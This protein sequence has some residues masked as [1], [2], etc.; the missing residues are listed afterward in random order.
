M[1][2]GSN[3]L[4]GLLVDFVSLV[5]FSKF[6]V[7]GYA[8]VGMVAVYFFGLIASSDVVNLPFKVKLPLFF[9]IVAACIVL[10]QLFVSGVL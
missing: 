3:F 5:D 2:A 1:L 9:V 10:S 7:P 8:T 6:V 4:T